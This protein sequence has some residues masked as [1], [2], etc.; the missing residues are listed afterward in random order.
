[1]DNPPFL[2][3]EALITQ[4]IR[5]EHEALAATYALL[6]QALDADQPVRREMLEGVIDSYYGGIEAL[7]LAHERDPLDKVTLDFL[8][9][10][11][12]RLASIM[13]L[14][15]R[16]PRPLLVMAK[17]HAQK[18]LD[19]APS[20]EF[21]ERA[22]DDIQRQAARLVTFYADQLAT[23]PELPPAAIRRWQQ[24]AF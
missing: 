22:L 23:G 11:Q 2:D 8:V 6:G 24:F 10:I 19:W 12:T 4:G 5:L 15:G 21:A 3:A 16:D 20:D 18:W 1:M 13:A 17:G 14:V 9:Q 7:T